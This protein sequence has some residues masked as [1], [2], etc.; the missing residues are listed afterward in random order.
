MHQMPSGPGEG[1]GLARRAADPGL[2]LAVMIADVVS[3]AALVVSTASALYARQLGKS[4]ETVAKAAAA[5]ADA[6][7]TTADI[8]ADRRH[9]ALS[10]QF[11]VTFT[12]DP[13]DGAGDLLNLTLNGPYGLGWLDVVVAIIDEPG[14]DDRHDPE[15]CPK[16]GEEE[17]Q[18]FIRGPWKFKSSARVVPWRPTDGKVFASSKR[19][20]PLRFSLPDGN[21]KWGLPLER[22]E[23]GSWMG[24]N[25]AQWQWQWEREGAPIR[26]KITC[27]RGIDEWDLPA[28]EV[29]EV[30]AE[31]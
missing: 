24:L 28:F 14:H 11:E 21:D 22:T 23:P 16:V 19:T 18:E 10:P 5:A 29:F 1:D 27:R 2:P 20:N 26:L 6:A 8:E 25:Q 9:D 4:A 30:P 15:I 31:A 17:A 12:P 13:K 3:I 7:K